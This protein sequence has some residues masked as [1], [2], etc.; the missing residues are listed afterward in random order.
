MRKDY[1]IG[2][3]TMKSRIAAALKGAGVAVAAVSALIASSVGSASASTTYQNAGGAAKDSTSAYGYLA[4]NGS[5]FNGDYV[6]EY[7]YASGDL[8]EQWNFTIGNGASGTV[9]NL[10]SASSSRCLQDKA[11]GTGTLIIWDC[12]TAATNQ[13]WIDWNKGTYGNKTSWWLENVQTQN[14][15]TAST[16][17]VGLSSNNV[18]IHD[19]NE[20]PAGNDWMYWY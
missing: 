20:N 17:A 13:K 15:L 7:K 3:M 4:L 14:D 6:V 12:N 5:G 10:V 18:R 2:R 1:L 16:Q 8:T 19:A 9:H 11:D